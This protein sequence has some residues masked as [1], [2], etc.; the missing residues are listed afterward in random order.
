MSH[1][2][3]QRSGWTVCI[4]CG[5]VRNYKS[6][7]SPCRG[8]TKIALR[9]TTGGEQAEIAKLKRERQDVRYERD[10]ALARGRTAAQILIE[11]IG[12][13][14]PENVEETARRAVATLEA[15]R[16]KA[17]TTSEEAAKLRR[18]LGDVL[19]MRDEALTRCHTVARTLTDAIGASGFVGLEEAAARMVATLD[20]ARAD[21][22]RFLAERDA[23]RGQLY[24]TRED[25][26]ARGREI[27]EARTE[28]CAVRTALGNLIDS[29]TLEAGSV[30]SIGRNMARDIEAARVLLG[31]GRS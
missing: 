10:E 13:P 14:G 15:W 3:L 25:L 16:H 12:A 17:E 29:V 7:N 30:K 20:G 2:W 11:S 24:R 22:H 19:A 26:R 9:E 5:V 27:D 28:L 23:A 1:S 31:E 21:V 6:A 18:D 8:P 4:V